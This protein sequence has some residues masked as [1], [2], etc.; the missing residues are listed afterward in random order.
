[1]RREPSAR[2]RCLPAAVPPAAAPIRARRDACRRFRRGVT[3]LWVA[4]ALRPTCTDAGPRSRA[5]ESA[6]SRRPVG[7]Y[8]R[9]QTRS[10]RGEG[11]VAA[12][13]RSHG[14]GRH[15]AEQ[16]RMRENG[17]LSQ[18]LRDHLTEWSERTG[19]AVEVWALP[20]RE[21]PPKV[22]DNVYATVREALD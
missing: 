8:R 11:I 9:S 2:V 1:A 19:I 22:A 21:V 15:V 13:M 5:G 18:M 10:A 14:W 20:E 17:G 6:V 7:R 4:S 3:R 16:R 12:E